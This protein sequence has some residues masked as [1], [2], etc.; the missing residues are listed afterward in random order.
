MLKIAF[1]IVKLDTLFMC[2]KVWFIY[3]WW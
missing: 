1:Y 3:M 2:L